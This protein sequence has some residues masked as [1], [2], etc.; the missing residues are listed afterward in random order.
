ML[1]GA[2]MLFGFVS[3]L[4]AATERTTLRYVRW[5]KARRVRA[6]LRALALGS[7]EHASPAAA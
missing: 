2:L 3:A 4:K 5:R 7:H 1:W 6:E